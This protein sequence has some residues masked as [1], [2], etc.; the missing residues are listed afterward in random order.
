MGMSELRLI[1]C[2]LLWGFDVEEG[3]EGERVRFEDWPMPSFVD[4]G[5]M[6]VRIR[7]RGEAR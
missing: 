3:E 4:K 5:P 7:L 6:R 1:V 2:R